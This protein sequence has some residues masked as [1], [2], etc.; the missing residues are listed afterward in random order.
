MYNGKEWT[1]QVKKTD[2]V[3]EE[4]GFFLNKL[5][6]LKEEKDKKEKRTS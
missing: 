5:L 4:W 6:S 3:I 1:N 2:K